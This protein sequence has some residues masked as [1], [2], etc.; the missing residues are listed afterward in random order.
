MSDSAKRS[1][2]QSVLGA[3]RG[4]RVIEGGGPSSPPPAG[5]DTPDKCPVT[6]LGHL[7]G[8][9]YFLDV[10][11][12]KRELTARQLGARHDLVSLFGGSDTWLREAFPKR[13]PVKSAD[14][15]GQESTVFRTVDFR[16]ND[17]AAGLQR[18]CFAVGLWG[19]HITIRKPGIWRD[20]DGQPAV[21]CG[22]AVLIGDTWHDPG[23]RTGNQIW[24]AAAPAKRP[25]MP[26][27]AS[28]GCD[29]RD[30]LV[31]LWNWREVGSP[32]AVLGLI[33]N[34]YYGAATEWRP[35]SFVTGS[36]GSGK[37]ALLRVMRAAVPLH[38]YDNDT[39]KAGIEQAVHGRAMAIIID[40]AADRANRELRPR[41]GRSRALRRRR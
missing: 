31:R 25:G 34:A 4:L 2:R 11:G 26:C 22:D 13:V 21:H 28:I 40:E 41:L 32:I 12:Q 37:S 7:D 10:R 29:L 36:T 15:T 18:A 8:T 35:A 23:A 19:D 24:A 6:P 30:G 27:A 1:I 38:H 33:A 14:E 39:S 5:T 17:A 3:D 9:F 16:I 20:V